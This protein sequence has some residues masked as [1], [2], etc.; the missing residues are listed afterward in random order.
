MVRESFGPAGVAELQLPASFLSLAIQLKTPEDLNVAHL[1]SGGVPVSHPVMLI[2]QFHTAEI[3]V[4]MPKS[5]DFS[6]TETFSDFYYKYCF[7]HS[8]RQQIDSEE[9]GRKEEKTCY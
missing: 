5:M 1:T 8:T 3:P 6:P 2:S 4:V 7:P 9:R